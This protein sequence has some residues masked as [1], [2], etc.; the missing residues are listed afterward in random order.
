MR[1]V[2]QTRDRLVIEDR[3]PAP[4]WQPAFV[5]VVLTLPLLIAYANAIS[6]R[7]AWKLLALV[8]V[9]WAVTAAVYACI[10]R[11][12][13]PPKI[14]LDATAGRARIGGFEYALSDIAHVM[15]TPLSNAS[16][17]TIVL[18]AERRA[19][20]S[21]DAADETGFSSA[22]TSTPAERSRVAKAINSFL[23]AHRDTTSRADPCRDVGGE[24]YVD[25][26]AD[27]SEEDDAVAPDEDDEGRWARSWDA[28]STT[29]RKCFFCATRN[30][31]T[32]PLQVWAK[33]ERDDRIELIFVP[34]CRRCRRVHNWNK[35]F[36]PAVAVPA[37]LIAGLMLFI[38]RVADQFHT[39]LTRIGGF[40]IVVIGM[41]LAAFLVARLV[42]S[43]RLFG[44]TDRDAW[45]EIPEFERARKEG[46]N[47]R[48][49]RVDLS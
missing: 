21:D 34:R 32:G 27:S 29:N 17:L 47:L 2:E 12:S 4:L 15:T 38:A 45:K 46:W 8:M 10:M 22:A 16:G 3:K 24:Y 11:F 28:E 42:T 18:R 41:P 20:G 26:Y 30:G 48:V 37:G 13:R 23:D 35:R 49:R 1:I 44:S 33:R 25:P 43:P 40:A 19:F 36:L 39:A 6:Q 31:D 9:I 7:G 14:E 5:V